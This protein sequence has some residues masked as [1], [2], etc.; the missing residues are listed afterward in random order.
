VN[1]SPSGFESSDGNMV[2]DGA[3]STDWNCFVGSDNFQSGTPDANCDVTSGAVHVTADGAGEVEWVN[4]QKFDSQCPK[5]STGNNPPKDEFTDI[6]SYNEA[7]SVGNDVFFYGATMRSSANGNSSGDVEF[8]QNAGDG[9]TTA[10]C[11]TAGDKLLAYDYLNGGTSLNFHVLT[12][13][14]SA[15]KTLGGNNGKCFVKT[16]A[17]PCWG[18]NVVTPDGSLFD[19]QANQSAITAANNG[20]SGTPLVVNQFAEFGVNLTQ[21]LGLTGCINFP[22][23]VWESRSSGSS[24]TSNPHDIEIE[25][26]TIQTCGEIRIIKQTDPRGQTGTFSFTSTL[27]VQAN[28]GGVACT[29]GGSSGIDASGNFCLSDAGNSS[30][31]LGDPPSGAAADNS[32]GNT[33]DATN[34]THGS[35][36]VTESSPP[37]SFSFETLSCSADTSSGSSVQVSGQTATISL[38]PSGTVTCIY[39]NK[40]HSGAIVVTKTGKD[41]NC[42]AA[43]TTASNG[44]LCTGSASAKLGGAT[45]S[46]TDGTNAVAGSPIT[47]ASS[48]AAT[49][50]ACID[51]LPWV[52]GGTTY[53]VTETG[54][55]TGF[56]KDSGTA[57]AVVV[58]QNASCS[59]ST[60]ANAATKTF[61][62]SPLTNL[63]V[64]ATSQVAGATNTTVTCVKHDTT[65]NIGNSPQGPTD[66]ATVTASGTSGLTPGVY[67]C[68]V[69]VDP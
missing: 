20:I 59:D 46:V 68:T 45:F 49:G 34:V 42:T 6:A 36:T 24:F 28:A 51:G 37:G 33:V 47:T 8:N 10:G 69:N 62:D 1:N 11:R 14:D 52:T 18:A 48:G 16:D 67:D 63:T 29:V 38:S 22:Q 66:P 60:V 15:N 27:P 2:L 39:V 61:T 50:T 13:I 35:Y 25:S 64:T 26:H 5:L 23:Q 56:A 55:P 53:Y 21:A 40:L 43:S 30:K 44:V 57:Q 19:G 41:K 3:S 4:G 65:T 58:S 17:L 54:A 12:W 32:S 31:T 7:A 9:T